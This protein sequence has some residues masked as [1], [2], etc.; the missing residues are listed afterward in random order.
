[1]HDLYVWGE[2]HAGALGNGKQEDSLF[3][4][5]IKD[6]LFLDAMPS[7][8]SCGHQIAGACTGFPSSRTLPLF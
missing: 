4:I 5:V 2:G 3:P 6:F 1:M 7:G 8:V